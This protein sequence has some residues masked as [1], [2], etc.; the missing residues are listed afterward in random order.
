MIAESPKRWVY[1]LPSPG[2]DAAADA[3]AWG[4]PVALARW[5]RARGIADADAADRFLRPRLSRLDDPFRLPDMPAAV[6]RIAR[7]IAA[8]E[9]IAVFGDYDVDGISAT[10][11]TL[12][13]LRALEAEAVPFLPHRMEDGYGLR[14]ESVRRCIEE[15]GARLIV[16]VDCGINS[17]EAVADARAAGVDVVVT[18]HHVP[19]AAAQPE[20]C[21]VVNP[22]RAPEGE[23]WRDLAG[24]GVAFKLC[25]ALL[26]EGRGRSRPEAHRFDLRARLDLVALGTLADAVPLVGENRILARHGM[27]RL[28]RAP[29]PGL[30]ALLEAASAR[31]EIGSYH[32]GY[33]IGPRLNAA[34]RLG[35]ARKAFDLL[36]AD[37]PGVA[38]AIAIELDAANR[39]RQN[40]EAQTLAEAE[41][42]IERHFDPDRDFAI[43]VSGRD[44]HPGV[45]GIVAS[46]LVARYRRPT[47]VITESADGRARGSSRGIEGFHLVEALA[48]CGAG[49]DSFGGHAMA[50]GLTLAADRVPLLR[51]RLSAYAR[52]RL[53][54]AD[55][56]PEQ[57]IDQ[58]IALA[59]ADERL[60]EAQ[61]DLRP[62]GA[63]NPAPVWGAR[64]VRV[65]R[66][67]TVGL[68]G[69]HRRFTFSDGGAQRDAIGFNL[70]ARPV[71]DG[72]LDIAFELQMDDYNGR[73]AV[74]LN[75]RDFRAA[76]E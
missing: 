19:D 53:A 45:I 41:A 54:G 5:L 60:C 11:L 20:A 59:E 74:Q 43:V 73:R 26:K 32:V 40:I 28:S 47:V 55:L 37:D 46:R 35:T 44:W 62:F 70:G 33:V 1:P 25:H 63:D 65:L 27:D 50:A 51:E 3:A 58:W 6:E 10:A 68:E 64:G 57:R 9:R 76:E 14:V 48:A 17:A 39:E 7:A 8:R 31:G 13:T 71:P 16:T 66:S 38:R 12:T 61:R 24:V 56:R 23:P 2:A 42:W 69:R 4:V 21:A 49:L 34:G 75:L 52:E 22:K 36:M 29:S 15:T 18:D 72:P 30:R 67:D